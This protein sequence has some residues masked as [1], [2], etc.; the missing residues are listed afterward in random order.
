MHFNFRGVA[1]GWGKENLERMKA[2][3]ATVMH[4]DDI[5]RCATTLEKHKILWSS[6][7]V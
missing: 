4:V 3:G 5:R 6:N 7:N 2:L 1:F